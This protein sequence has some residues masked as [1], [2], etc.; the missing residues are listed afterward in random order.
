MFGAVV[1]GVFLLRI[2]LDLFLPSHPKNSSR[3]VA[4]NPPPSFKSSAWRVSA[5]Y[6]GTT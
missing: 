6:Q 3:F 4:L 1:L 2:S 5:M